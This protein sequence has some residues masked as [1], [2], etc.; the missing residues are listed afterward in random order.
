MSQTNSKFISYIM[1]MLNYLLIFFY[2]WNEKIKYR[3]PFIARGSNFEEKVKLMNNEAL[4]TYLKE[5]GINPN[6]KWIERLI[7]QNNFPS[8]NINQHFFSEFLKSD[9]SDTSNPLEFMKDLIS[10]MYVIQ[11][12][13][14]FQINEIVDISIPSY[15]RK[16]F[17]MSG[18]GTFKLLLS[19]GFQ[20]VLA[21]T[22]KVIPE[23]NPANDP[24]AKIYLKPPITVKFGVI[25]L[26]D[27]NSTIYG[28]MSPKEI[29][30][31][32]D[33]VTKVN[34]QNPT[35]QQ[36]SSTNNIAN[37]QNNLNQDPQST[38]QITQNSPTAQQQTNQQSKQNSL[39]DQP[40]TSKS[41]IPLSNLIS[42]ISNQRPT[43]I[44]PTNSGLQKLVNQSINSS[45]NSPLSSTKSTASTKTT[46]STKSTE[47]TKATKSSS[48]NS[49]Q[50]NEAP[51]NSNYKKSSQE[52]PKITKISKL[53]S[54]SK[55]RTMAKLTIEEEPLQVTPPS[56]P[57]HLKRFRK[58]VEDVNLFLSSDTSDIISDSYMFDSESDAVQE[59]SKPSK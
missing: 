37:H 4:I 42:T 11:E 44:K 33:I 59:I 16:H 41:N 20:S 36:N 29:Q 9:I 30:H 39:K 25:F 1:K 58:N 26:T 51:K 46:T 45:S 17:E 55:F 31:R 10:P 14:V 28:G 23:I 43:P 52:T 35:K 6:Q 49:S 27:T 54:Q 38:Q 56:D 50:S 13:V 47:S 24:G 8:A 48:R 21:I 12:P 7:S 19:D 53:S 18:K 3:R 34:K 2:D 40:K 32:N 5:K 15:K 57:S 22:K